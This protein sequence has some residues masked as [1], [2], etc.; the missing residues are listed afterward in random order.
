M[1][2][3]TSFRKILVD[4]PALLWAL[5]AA[6]ALAHEKIKVGWEHTVGARQR[7]RGKTY[8]HVNRARGRKCCSVGVTIARL[9]SANDIWD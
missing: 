2:F 6:P 9:V 5:D 7:V 3:R 8:S 4:L 1:T